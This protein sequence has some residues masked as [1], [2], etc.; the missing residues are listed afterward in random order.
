[1]GENTN[2]AAKLSNL[3]KGLKIALE[4]HYQWIITELYSQIIIHLITQILHGKHPTTISPSW[5]LSRLLEEFGAFLSPNLTTIPSHVKREANKVAD[6]LANE[7]VNTEI[8][9]I[10]WKAQISDFNDLSK[11]CQ[12]L[13]HRDLLPLDGVPHK[14]SEPHDVEPD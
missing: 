13:A 6:Y 7:G 8:E 14:P 12:E 10:H 2:N 3:L 4:N 11:R 9:K 1:M 5:H